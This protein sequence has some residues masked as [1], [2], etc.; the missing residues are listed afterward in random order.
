MARIFG[1]Q[2]VAWGRVQGVGFRYFVLVK[3]RSLGV[4]GYVRNLLDIRSV[5]IEAE[6]SQDALEELLEH[7]QLGSPRAKVDRVD[8]HWSEA[9][10]VYEK[11]TAVS[12]RPGER[13]VERARSRG[14]DSQ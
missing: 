14:V 6:G 13:P 9:T 11:F 7:I 8:A 3:A 2:A 4:V 5:E 1:L 12:G 10:D